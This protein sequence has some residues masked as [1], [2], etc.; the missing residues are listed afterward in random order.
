MY[1]VAVNPPQAD[2]MEPLWVDSLKEVDRLYKEDSKLA[3]WALAWLG[4]GGRSSRSSIVV[5]ANFTW[6][7]EHLYS[8]NMHNTRF[9]LALRYILHASSCSQ[10][11]SSCLSLSLLFTTPSHK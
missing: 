9:S 7:H 1:D 8:S 2:L 6:R 5:N 10:F 4:D 3:I 11:S